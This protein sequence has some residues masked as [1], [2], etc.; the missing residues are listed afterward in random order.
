MMF[1]SCD[2]VGTE[3]EQGVAESPV[4]LAMSEFE[5]DTEPCSGLH[6]VGDLRV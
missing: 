1:E 5:S 4:P 3:E 2:V 6:R